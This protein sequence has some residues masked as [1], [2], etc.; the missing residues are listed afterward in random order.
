MEFGVTTKRSLHAFALLVLFLGNTN[1]FWVLLGV[2]AYEIGLEFPELVSVLLDGNFLWEVRVVHMVGSNF[3][4]IALVLHMAKAVLSFRVVSL[5]K[6]V[7]WLTGALIFACTCFSV[8]R[9]RVGS[10]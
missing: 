1:C 3:V 9:V 4:I 10:R 8:P 2:M 7:I 6:A 5:V